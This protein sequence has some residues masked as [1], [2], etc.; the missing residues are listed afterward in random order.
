MASSRHTPPFAF[1]KPLPEP[2]RPS[3]W[4]T[5]LVATLIAVCTWA[6]VQIP[7]MLREQQR[8]VCRAASVDTMYLLVRSGVSDAPSDPDA[9][10]R[11]VCR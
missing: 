8:R 4:R 9:V 2:P 10:L 11:E 6:G 5:V 7:L 1:H 3:R